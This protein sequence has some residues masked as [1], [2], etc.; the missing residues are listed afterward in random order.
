VLM[1]T[2][3]MIQLLLPVLTSSGVTPPFSFLFWLYPYPKATF[4][5]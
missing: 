5:K 3:T 2:N 1:R 4:D